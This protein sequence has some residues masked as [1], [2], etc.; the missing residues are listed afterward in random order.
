MLFRFIDPEETYAWG[1]EEIARIEARMAA[2]AGDRTVAEALAAA[3]REPV[4][5]DPA[6]FIAEMQAR[7]AR[8]LELVAP[9]FD[10]PEPLRRLD[11]SAAPPTGHIGA[12]YVQPSE[13]FQRPGAISYLLAGDGPQPLWREVSTAYHEGIPG[14]H[15]QIGTQ[16][17][18]P[19]LSRF[20][21]VVAGWSGF[22][23]GWA[24][25][26]E[27][28][29][30]ELGGYELPAYRLGMLSN[31]HVRACRVVLDIGAHLDLPT[32]DGERWTFERGV[33]LLTTRAGLPEAH[34]RSEMTRYLGFPGQAISYKV[35]QRAMLDLRREW[36]ARGGTLRGFHERV[37][38]GGSVG[39]ARLR[40]RV[41]GR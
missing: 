22:A 27:E 15:L 35:G 25:Y 30:D 5:P 1:W 33:T 16:I 37:L 34:A 32:P 41:L 7:Q 39:L 10:V 3:A 13:D 12:Y 21:R 18:L 8:A 17:G 26:A 14:H 29:M 9:H 38:S 23:E 20:H 28:L 36:L 4:A 6:A 31:Q 2:I 24:L 19:A 11:V 40:E